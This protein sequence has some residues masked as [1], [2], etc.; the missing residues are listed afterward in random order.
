ML[1]PSVRGKLAVR[2][3]SLTPRRGAAAGFLRLFLT[4]V[5]L[6]MLQMDEILDPLSIIP[7]MRRQR[8]SKEE[9]LA[10]VHEGR[11]GRGKFGHRKGALMRQKDGG[12][13]TGEWATVSGRRF[14]CSTRCLFFF[15]I[16]VE[17]ISLPLILPLPPS[18]PHPPKPHHRAHQRDGKHNKQGQGKAEEPADAH[19]RA[20]APREAQPEPF[21]PTGAW[22]E[23]RKRAPLARRAAMAASAPDQRTLL[24]STFFFL[25]HSAPLKSRARRTA[26]AE[27]KGH[28]WTETGA[29]ILS[30]WRG[31]ASGN[32]YPTCRQTCYS[33]SFMLSAIRWH[34]RGQSSAWRA[35][36]SLF[37][38]PPWT[39]LR[40]PLLACRHRLRPC[41]CFSAQS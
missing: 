21:R 17:S 5:F 3:V 30:D 34:P 33:A 22:R 39:V 28:P 15:S 32:T 14:L 29:L 10:Q 27:S 1:A 4:C 37:A 20:R 26:V 31:A 36:F 7:E 16:H 2:D 13:K 11:E 6:A 23:W 12:W 9:R 38:W 24:F 40:L 35:T 18:P 25:P 8:Q 41:A 19:A